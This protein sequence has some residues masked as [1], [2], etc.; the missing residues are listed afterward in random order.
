MDLD[1]QRY[2]R[3][4]NDQCNEGSTYCWMS[5]MPNPPQCNDENAICYD[6]VQEQECENDPLVHAFNCLVTC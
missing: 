6:T 2:I 3:S 1:S 5:C 4:V